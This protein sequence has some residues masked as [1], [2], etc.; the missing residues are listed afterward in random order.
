MFIAALF[1]VAR[2]WRQLRY[3]SIEEQIQKM[4]Y[5]YTMGYYSDIE[6]K[7]ITNFTGKWM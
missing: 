4:W 1:V 3:L 5:I 6:N 2:N 7:D